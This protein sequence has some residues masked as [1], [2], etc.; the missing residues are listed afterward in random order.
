MVFTVKAMWLRKVS[1]QRA[2]ATAARPYMAPRRDDRLVGDALWSDGCPTD[3]WL[4]PR[5]GA[6]QTH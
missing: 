6:Q 1:A 5:H 4:S 3:L 2:C